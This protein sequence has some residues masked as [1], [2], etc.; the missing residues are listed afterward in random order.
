MPIRW[1]KNGRA[2]PMTRERKTGILIRS[3]GGLSGRKLEGPP[4]SMH[5]GAKEDPRQ[6]RMRPAQRAG[7]YIPYS[8]AGQ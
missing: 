5:R 6:S 1:H 4:F 3:Q 2:V 8:I 7:E